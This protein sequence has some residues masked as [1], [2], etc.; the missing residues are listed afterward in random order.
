LKKVEAR[1]VSTEAQTSQSQRVL[2]Q[3]TPVAGVEKPR[4][5]ALATETPEV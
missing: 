1:R 5:K 3:E 4:E 2:N